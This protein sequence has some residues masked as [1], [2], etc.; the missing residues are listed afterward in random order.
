MLSLER[1]RVLVAVAETGSVVGAARTL[2]VTTSAVSQQLA[3]L[4]RETG[5]ALTERQGRGLRL[6]V[7]G[8]L[9]AGQA[10]EL[11]GHAER[12]EAALAAHLGTVAGRLVV[13]GFATAARGL[14]PGVLRTLADRH[15]GLSVSLRELEPD[16]AVAALR[17]GDI[18]LAIVQDWPSDDALSRQH[19]LDDA[20]DL[21]V[22]P[23]HPLAGRSRVALA[24]VAGEP[25]ISWPEGQLCHSWLRGMLASPR[26][27]HTAGEH[28]TQ[29]ALVAAGLGV[30]LIPRLGRPPAAVAYVPVE[31]PLTRS[32]D[33]LWR[34]SYDQ[35]PAVS[36]FL[37]AICCE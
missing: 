32:V 26:I 8:S 20:F 16:V 22:A 11:L 36:A 2:H 24:D 3:R 14:L 21:A 19:L 28:A 27:V 37:M 33:V 9:L 13:A 23:G 29:L 1:L 7:A 34:A 4:E 12:V 25:W 5:Q 10:R 30:A 15:P 18:D 31:P 35:H 17:R 6:T